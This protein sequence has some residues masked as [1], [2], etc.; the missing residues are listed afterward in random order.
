MNVPRGKSGG[1]GIGGLRDGDA[2]FFAVQL[3]TGGYPVGPAHVD[4]G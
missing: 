2:V 1:R 4:G 3:V